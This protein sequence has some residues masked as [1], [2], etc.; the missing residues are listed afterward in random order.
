MALRRSAVRRI[1]RRSVKVISVDIG[2]L[3]FH[4]SFPISFSWEESS[5]VRR[6]WSTGFFRRLVEHAKCEI[7]LE[8]LKKTLHIFREVIMKPFT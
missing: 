3:G 2:F 8:V 5:R 7:I 1:H 4:I 6:G